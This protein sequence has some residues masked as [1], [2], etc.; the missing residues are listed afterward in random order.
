MS[1][2]AKTLINISEVNTPTLNA[3]VANIGKLSLYDVDNINCKTGYIENLTIK[4]LTVL[5]DEV[6]GAEDSSETYEE[7]TFNN[8]NINFD[9]S[10]NCKYT[11][12]DNTILVNDTDCKMLTID[13][14]VPE[15]LGAKLTCRYLVLDMREESVDTDIVTFFP[16]D[17]DT[18]WKLKWL[19]GTPDIQAGYFYVLA[20]QRFANDLI[21]G[22]VAVKI[23][24]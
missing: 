9:D 10:Y 8:V 12:A 13:F 14:T 22:N 18:T 2:I 11:M 23:E 17:T 4:E 7:A 19:Y 6:E 16:D 21:I 5:E 3:N 15:T 20:F 1:G 24:A